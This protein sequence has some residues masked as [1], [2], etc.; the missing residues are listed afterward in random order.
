MHKLCNINIYNLN[1]YFYKVHILNA[2]F[3]I[4]K[5]PPDPEAEGVHSHIYV[6]VLYF[7][8]ILKLLWETKYTFSPINTRWAIL[9]LSCLVDV[10]L[11]VWNLYWFSWALEKKKL[12][13][14]ILH[15]KVNAWYCIKGM[16]TYSIVLDS[17]FKAVS[18]WS[19]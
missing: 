17:N 13:A 14:S 16:N 1:L 6:W 4:L 3:G 10:L 19:T 12:L 8:L 18:S 9:N 2:Q 15:R 7:F 5:S 11:E